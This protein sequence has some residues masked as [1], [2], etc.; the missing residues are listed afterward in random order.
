[1]HCIAIKVFRIPRGLTDHKPQCPREAGDEGEMTSP[2][3]QEVLR[4][5]RQRLREAIGVIPHEGQVIALCAVCTDW[6]GDPSERLVVEG[7]RIWRHEHDGTHTRIA[8]VRNIA[9]PARGFPSGGTTEGTE[10][11]VVDMLLTLR[12]EGLGTRLRA[13]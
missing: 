8:D 12:D 13:C 2:F 3:D 9:D 10:P 4:P 11:G 7:D 1:V 5:R 6:N